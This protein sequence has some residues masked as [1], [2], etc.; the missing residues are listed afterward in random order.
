[1]QSCVKEN[2][3]NPN[4]TPNSTP[5]PGSAKSTSIF[6][7]HKGAG[8]NNYNDVNMEHSIASFK[9]A[10]TYLDGVEIDAQMSL[11]GTIWMFHDV[12]INASLC[13]PKAVHNSILTLHDNQIAALQLCHGTK[14]DRVYKLSELIDLWNSS[15]NGFYLD[16]EI[17]TAI[18]KA[19]Y[20]SFG[21]E[22]K[23]LNKMAE[24]MDKIFQ[25][26]KHSPK[27]LQI[28]DYSVNFTTNMRTYKSGKGL[29]YMLNEDPPFDKNVADAIS[30]KFDGVIHI[31]TDPAVTGASVLNAHNKG[32]LVSLF[33]PYTDAEV[34]STY[35]KL[36]DFIDTDHT[37]VKKDL[38]IH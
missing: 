7:G 27:L 36:P 34:L 8:S 26:L 17:K 20:V 5:T 1:M 28:D 38:N 16:I 6:L 10:L 13:N 11:D 19:D 2:I 37:T 15:A 30:G 23:Y 33:A 21:G 4:G 31:F 35:Q 9:E 12:D 3:I 29:T 22:L 24:S 32:L 18:D 14:K 25:N